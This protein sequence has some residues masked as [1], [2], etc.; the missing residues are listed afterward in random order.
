[1][2]K[3]LF[4]MPFFLVGCA[5]LQTLAYQRKDADNSAW[6]QQQEP[7][8]K[9][10]TLKQAQFFVN[11]YNRLNTP[12]VSPSDIIL[13]EGVNKLIPAARELDGGQIT[14]EQFDD[15]YRSVTTEVRQK[16]ADL[17]AREAQA[18]Q[19]R[20]NAILQYYMM[21]KP[22]T[23]NCSGYGGYATCTSY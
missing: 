14:Q 15:L 6:M 12:P 1:M 22:V 16:F 20:R 19:Q 8:I 17:R 11:Y 21:T 13:M 4:L 18:E 7:K 5:N 9:D 23:T 10:G 3:M 2:K